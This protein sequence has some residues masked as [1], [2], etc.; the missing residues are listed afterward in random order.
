MRS[1]ILKKNI[2][3]LPH[4]ALLMSAGVRREDFEAG[5]PFIGVANSF[6]NLIPGHIHLDEL[7][8]EVCRGIRDAGGVPFQWGV[9]GVC[10]GIAMFVEMRLSLPSREHIA[11]N[12]EIMVLSHSLDGWVGVTN[13]DK[14]TPGML[15]AAARMDLPAV[16]L[17]GGPMKAN[18]IQG[19]KCHPIVGFGI[20]GRVKAGKITANEAE[21]M[22]GDMVCGAGSCVGLYTA[23]TMAVVTEALGMSLTRCATTIALDP[24]KKQQAYESGRRIVE[25]VKA[26]VRPRSI[27]TRAAFENAIRVDMAMGG[28]TNTVL[29]IPAI[30]REAG[31]NIEVEEFDRISRQTPN[32]CSIIP[33]GPYEMADVDAAGGI[34][35]VLKRLLPLLNENPTVTGSSIRKVA[36]EAVVV[37]S[38]VIRSTDN[39]YHAEGGIAVLKGNIA[40]SAVVKQTAVNPEMLVFTGPAKVFFTEEALLN[41]IA[42]GQ[43]AEGDVVVLPFQGPAGGP[44]M[45]EMLTPTDAIKGAGYQRVALITDGRFSGATSGLSVGHVEMEAYN[46]GPIAAIQNGDIIDFDVP[47]RKMDVRLTPVQIRDRLLAVKAPERKLPR[48]L[49]TFRKTY[50]GINCYGKEATPK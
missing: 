6:N 26:D 4:R 19:R 50:T 47:Q 45:P 42:A 9:P 16:I 12:I 2:E 24:K 34:P 41:A 40:S 20:V 43:I 35:A 10:D 36:S 18:M 37:D 22:L 21:Q 30:A 5:K 14:I 39:P 27:M 25:L 13:C 8:R 28:S 32:L 38:Q 49:E 44:G 11:D 1:D 29:H 31:I 23:N 46:G 48:M 17:T 7:T 15:M 33:G 3:T